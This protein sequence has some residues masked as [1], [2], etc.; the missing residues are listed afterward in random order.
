MYFLVILI[1][2]RGLSQY[3]A[4]TSTLSISSL[5]ASTSTL[6]NLS[7]FMATA[8]PTPFLATPRPWNTTTLNELTL[9]GEDA[10]IAWLM[11]KGLLAPSADWP[12]CGSFCRMAKHK[13]SPI[14][15]CPRKGCQTRVNI[16]EGSFFSNKVELC[17]SFKANV[18]LDKTTESDKDSQGCGRYTQNSHWYN[19]CRDICEEHSITIGGPGKIVEIDESKFGKYTYTFL[20]ANCI[21]FHM[22]DLYTV[23]YTHAGKHKYNRGR[24]VDGHWVFG[25][26]ERGSSQAFMVVVSDRT[27]ITLLPIIQHYIRP[28][29]TIY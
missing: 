7:L 28:G 8:A 5:Q 19:F 1:Y 11:A 18:S 3:E 29:T 16:K 27:K 17:N 24:Q 2:K 10:L 21:S 13:H 15:R 25:G 26:I 6:S 14:W 4:S 12:K 23:L 20:T 22:T 9:R